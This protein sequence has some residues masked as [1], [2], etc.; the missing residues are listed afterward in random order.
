MRILEISRVGLF[1]ALQPDRT[2]WIRWGS[3]LTAVEPSF[4]EAFA[5]STITTALWRMRNDA[6]DLVVLPAVQPSH[7]FGQPRNKLIAKSIL[8][9]FSRW[10]AFG[11][12]LS[13]LILRSNRH[14]IVDIGDERQLCRTTIRLFPGNTL[15]FKRELDL[16]VMTDPQASDRVRPL[17]LFVPDERSFPSPHKKD[18]DIFFAGALCN[19]VRTQALEAAQK[20]S[21]LGVRVAMPPSPLPYPE[22]I[23]AA[24]RSWL[25]LS[26]EGHGWD[27]YRHYEACFA[28]AV[29]VINRPSYRR[30]SYLKMVLTAFT[31]MLILQSLADRLLA[32]L[33][34]KS[35][36]C[37][38]GCCRPEAP[39]KPYASRGG[40]YML[41]EI[42][43]RNANG[44]T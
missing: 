16:D 36:A 20:L 18:I 2:H 11:R 42:F 22:F 21:S 43:E 32:F 9:A 35:S 44:S 17:S 1:K 25:V 12:M 29:P 37:P 4:P 41:K 13:H 6:Y 26:P 38:D 23:A 5:S 24:A 33:V 28:G 3:P 40:A 14:I 10:H 39:R 7:R 30:H 34:D 31:M 27:C 15:Y 19:T 8:E